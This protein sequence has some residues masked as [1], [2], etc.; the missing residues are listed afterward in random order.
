MGIRQMQLQLRLVLQLHPAHPALLA[1]LLLHVHVRLLHVQIHAVFLREPLARTVRALVQLL[2]RVHS[3]VYRQ[4]ALGPE[5][6]VADIA[7]V[8][9]QI[10]VHQAVHLEALLVE[11]VGAADAAQEAPVADVDVVV[12]AQCRPVGVALEADGALERSRLDA[13]VVG[14]HVDRQAHL[15]AELFFA[16]LAEKLL[17][18]V[19][20]HVLHELAAVGEGQRAV[21][22]LDG[23]ARTRALAVLQLVQLAVVVEVVAVAE[24]LLEQLQAVLDAVGL[25]PVHEGL[26]DAVAGLLDWWL[27]RLGPTTLVLWFAAE[28]PVEGTDVVGDV[29]GTCQPQKVAGNFVIQPGVGDWHVGL[30]RSRL[31][32]LLALVLAVECVLELP[33]VVVDAG[34]ARLL[35]E[36]ARDLRVVDLEALAVAVLGHLVEAREGVEALLAVKVDGLLSLPLLLRFVVVVGC[37]DFDRYKVAGLGVV[38]ETVEILLEPERLLLQGRELGELDEAVLADGRVLR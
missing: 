35:H 11:K 25:E 20:A 18:L 13:L 37:L 33:V 30:P 4:L 17:R 22:A 14:R 32:H 9:P 27:L 16:R 15:G 21:L 1:H 29:F 31:L 10:L 7:L 5:A 23:V 6:L 36:L 34:L 8:R 3:H 38:V 2:A 12:R 26:R 24:H 28:R 19:R